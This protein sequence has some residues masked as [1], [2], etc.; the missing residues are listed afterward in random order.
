MIVGDVGLGSAAAWS[1]V[2]AHLRCCISAVGKHWG[3]QVSSLRCHGNNL[4]VKLLEAMAEIC[5]Q[6]RLCKV[7]AECGYDGDRLLGKQ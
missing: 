4:C 3:Q 1:V 7:R 6:F 5:L 2:V